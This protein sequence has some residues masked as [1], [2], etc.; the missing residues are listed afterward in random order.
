MRFRLAIATLSIAAALLALLAA[1]KF[2]T[3]PAN[4]AIGAPP[5]DLKAEA[6]SFNDSLG[7]VVK[8]WSIDGAPDTGAVLLLHG[9]KAYRRSM[10][11]RTGF[12]SAEGYSILMIDLQ[13]HGESAGDHIAFGHGEAKSVSAAIRF[14]RTKWQDKRLSV[15]GT[16]LGGAAAIFVAREGRA[17]AYILETVYSTLREATENRLRIR[18]GE[19]GSL[20]APLLLW[21][22]PLWLGFDAEAL[23]PVAR[24]RDLGAPVLIIAGEKDRRTTL[25]NS[26][27]LFAGA[28]E[29]KALWVISGA[30]HQD[31]L[32]FS[33]DAYKM[34]VLAFLEQHLN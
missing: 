14:A 12:L 25:A 16:S 34:R 29:P 4:R 1:G 6:V 19:L 15:I 2:A 31:F 9:V 18:F 26:K 3:L 30:R 27:A 8:G 7:K 22:T 5:D 10:V 32:R 24:I 28:V 17:D 11:R 21:Q 33:P 20:L 23:S 13:A